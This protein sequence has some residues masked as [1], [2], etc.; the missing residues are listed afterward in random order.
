MPDMEEVQAERNARARAEVSNPWWLNE[1]VKNAKNR[2]ASEMK[3]YL[4]RY[5]RNDG[6]W[7]N[8]HWDPN[9]T[10]SF[11]AKSDDEAMN[12]ALGYISVNKVG[13]EDFWIDKLAEVKFEKREVVVQDYKPETFGNNKTLERKLKGAKFKELSDAIFK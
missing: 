9:P 4:V 3:T 5:W 7:H 8:D 1:K 11:Y 2:K 12:I 6:S 13:N 10:Y